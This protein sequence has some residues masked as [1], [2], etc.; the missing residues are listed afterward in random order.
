MW[1]S[2]EKKSQSHGFGADRGQRL[3]LLRFTGQSNL[4][5]L[6]TSRIYFQHFPA[7]LIDLFMVES[8]GDPSAAPL[9]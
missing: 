8:K 1:G 9:N 3:V 2:R 6:K 5:T 4:E 7:L